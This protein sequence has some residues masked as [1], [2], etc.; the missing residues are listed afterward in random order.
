MKLDSEF[1]LLQAVSGHWLAV[2][3]GF[4]FWA[5]AQYDFDSTAA[6]FSTTGRE[7]EER[8]GDIV[9]HVLV[10]EIGHHFGLS[11]DDIDAIE[12]AAD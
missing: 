11:D 4:F 5:I 3:G 6:Q 7:H 1:D 10:H 12:A 2:S 9:T 8:L